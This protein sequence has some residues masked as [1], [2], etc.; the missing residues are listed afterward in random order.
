MITSPVQRSAARAA[1]PTENGLPATVSGRTFHGAI[2]RLAL[3]AE[4]NGAAI[5]LSADVP[6]RTALALDDHAPVTLLIAPDHVRLFP[7]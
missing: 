1:G 2:T 5:A 6:S 4:V 3:L 7:V